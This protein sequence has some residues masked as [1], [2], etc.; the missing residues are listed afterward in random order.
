MKTVNFTDVPLA[1]RPASKIWQVISKQCAQGQAMIF[2][3]SNGYSVKFHDEPEFIPFE[4]LAYNSEIGLYDKR[5][6][7]SL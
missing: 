5:Q 3:D 6:F 7:P 2:Q 4:H 1:Q